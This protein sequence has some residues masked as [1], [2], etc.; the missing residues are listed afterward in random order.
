MRC[1]G[2]RGLVVL[3]EFV[4]HHLVAGLTLGR[5]DD[6]GVPGRDAPRRRRRRSAARA[7]RRRPLAASDLGGAGR[8]LPARRRGPRPR[9]RRHLPFA[10][11]RGAG[12]RVRLRRADLGGSDARL[13]L[14]RAGRNPAGA[15]RTASR[16]SRASGHLNV[17][18]ARAA[19]PCSAF[20]A[21]CAAAS[22][23][24]CSSWP[25][26]L[27]PDC[28][29]DARTLDDGVLRLDYQDESRPV[30]AARRLRG[31]REPPLARRW[32][33]PRG[34]RSAHCRSASLSSSA[35]PA[36]SRSCP[37]RSPPRFRSTSTRSR[38]LPPSSSC[39]PRTMRCGSE[40]APPRPS[41]SDASM[42]W[43]G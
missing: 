32:A 35:T 10:V 23:T 4:L 9:G 36:G 21:R 42:T 17:R 7:R 25:E 1:G 20:D 38:R 5:G 31:Q 26:A 3:H 43:I 2:D 8:G 27:R 14:G 34:W 12:A 28:G 33:R 39:W 40:W 13:A 30:A 19:A 6:D 15:G 29:L 37:T 18:E 24:H 11:R 22:P 16:S 41:T